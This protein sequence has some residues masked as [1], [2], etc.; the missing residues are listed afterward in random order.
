MASDKVQEANEPTIMNK[1]KQFFTK[2][3]AIYSSTALDWVRTFPALFF[4]FIFPLIMLLMMGFIFGGVA[5]ETL[6]L[7]YTN[8]DVYQTAD[9]DFQPYHPT[10]ELLERLGM[11][12]E[13]L[14]KE[15]NLDLRKADFNSTTDDPVEYTK[16]RDL[17]N[18]M[19]IPLGWSA[20]INASKTNP[21]ASTANISYYYNPTYTNSYTTYQIVDSVLQEMNLD[22]F[23]ITNY[24]EFTTEGTPGR[25]ELSMI[26]FYVPGLIVVSYASAS[27]MGLV[28]I[29]TEQRRNGL[30][31]HLSTTTLTKWEWLIGHELWQI[32]IALLISLLTAVTAHFVFGFQLAMLHPLMFVV[33]IFT[34]IAFSGMAFIIARFVT[35]PEAASAAALTIVFPMMFISNTVIPTFIMPEYL[36]TIAKFIPLYYS[37]E[38]LKTLML[39][40]TR[41]S[42]GYNFGILVA[43]SIALFVIGAL[44]FKWKKE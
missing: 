40:S 29:V 14:Q 17:Y 32:T 2:I 7:Y 43:I 30:L 22:E 6:I 34:S 35:R 44:L 37:A 16:S 39:E 8:E 36:Q 12:N 20:S 4:T 13:T 24:F 28:S 42:F 3:Y 21:Y 31:D 19:V 11:N 1:V 18:L 41:S 5:D 15:L 9:G 38:A 27:I 10:D 33:L 23:G 26:D 25:E